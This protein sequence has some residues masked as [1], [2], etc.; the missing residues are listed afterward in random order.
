[1]TDLIIRNA[2]IINENK[3]FVGSVLIEQGKITQIKQGDCEL[4]SKKTLDAT[5][6]LLIPGVIDDHVHFREPGFTHKADIWH[7][8][9]AAAAGGV[10][11]YMEMPNTDPRTV[12]RKTL[13]HK[14]ELAE[15][16][17]LVN[18][19]FYIGGTNDNLDELNKI[20]PNQVCGIKLF[21]GSSTGNM[22]IDNRESLEKIF[23]Q[24]RIPVA[25]H[26]EDEFIIKTNLENFRKTYGD[27]IPIAFHPQI[28]SEEACYKATAEAIEL[29]EKYN[30]R[31][32]IL[33]L[34]TEKELKLFKQGGN[35]KSKKITSEVCI[36]HLLFNDSDYETYGTRI[37]WNPAIKS[38]RDQHALFEGLLNDVIDIIATDHAPHTIEEKNLDYVHSP[39]GGPLIQHSLVAMLEYY[40]KGKI[41]LGKIV[42]KMSHSPAEI[43]QVAKRGYI[44]EGYWADLVLI[45]PKSPWIVTKDNIRSKCGWSPFEG[46]VF[47]SKVIATLVNGTVVYSNEQIVE[48]KA[49][50]PLEFER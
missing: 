2:T 22:L 27:A 6:L 37:K 20:D 30:T 40:K 19:S 21:L 3:Q 41:S 7:E 11:S 9:R 43:F 47:S 32:H 4:K 31:L 39:S 12:T 48:E 8:S 14:F 50:M 1:M 42:E 49:A 16:N 44:R 45:D 36:H 5:N 13:Q 34:S 17:S 23:S 35:L 29:A 28:R 46:I 10:T 18:Y 26:S 15:N 25:I 24:S 33:H 38:I